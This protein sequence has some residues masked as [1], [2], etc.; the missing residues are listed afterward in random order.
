MIL[1]STF[2]TRSGILGD[3]S[4]HSFTDLGLSGQLLL[5]LFSFIFISTYYLIKRWKTIPTSEKE[6]KK[7]S[8]DFWLFIGVFTLLLMAFQVIFPTSIPVYN[9]IVGFF[10]GF[11]FNNKLYIE[12]NSKP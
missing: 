8:A 11:S 2:L 6:I 1:Y 3:S 4:V 12:Q 5:Y 10:G 7:Y 9:S